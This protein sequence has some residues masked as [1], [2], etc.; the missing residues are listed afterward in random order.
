VLLPIAAAA[1]LIPARR[2]A[3]AEPAAVLR[4]D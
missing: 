1:S 2:A 3:G 4:G